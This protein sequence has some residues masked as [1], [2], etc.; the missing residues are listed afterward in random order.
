MFFGDWFASDR[1]GD[2]KS[3]TQ[4]KTLYHVNSR[5]GLNEAK[6]HTY[7][8]LYD[9]LR[10]VGICF[11]AFGHR[12]LFFSFLSDQWF[13]LTETIVRDRLERIMDVDV[14]MWQ[15]ATCFFFK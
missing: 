15:I 10:L 3:R 12:R 13:L 6:S 4:L 9:R 11:R 8:P 14:L 5:R 7:S 1:T 2:Q